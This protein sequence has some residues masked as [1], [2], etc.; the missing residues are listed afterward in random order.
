[1]KKNIAFVCIGNSSRSQ[2][3]ESWAKKIAAEN[4]SIYSAGTRPGKGIKDRTKDIMKEVSC[5]MDGQF[6][7]PLTELP[8]TIDYL[9][10]MGEGVDCPD[11]GEADRQDW[12]FPDLDGSDLTAL[13]D[14]RDAIGEK[15]KALIS[16]I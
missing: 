8:E 4:H 10:L 6:P 2:M 3:A 7:K 1:M 15:V 11:L 14:L 12:G 9:I 5:S 13:K 16:S